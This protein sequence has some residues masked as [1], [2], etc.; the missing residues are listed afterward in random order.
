METI[1]STI[2]NVGNTY[3]N[4]ATHI[5][6]AVIS[7]SSIAIALTAV[8]FST[9]IC[10]LSMPYSAIVFGSSAFLSLGGIVSSIYNSLYSGN[11]PRTIGKDTASYPETIQ[12]AQNKT[13]SS[14]KQKSLPKLTPSALTKL[15]ALARSLKPELKQK[16]AKKIQRGLDTTNGSNLKELTRLLRDALT[17]N[18]PIAKMITLPS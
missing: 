3:H 15:L 12:Q 1:S 18:N 6:S 8:I 7:A 10:A 16:V 17:C 5:N 13:H 11:S 4:N 2:R 9:Q 14:R